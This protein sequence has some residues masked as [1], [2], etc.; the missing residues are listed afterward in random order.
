MKKRRIKSIANEEGLV[1]PKDQ[2]TIDL[3]KYVDTFVEEQREDKGILIT[4]AWI[5]KF[6]FESRDNNWKRL[7]VCN[8][9]TYLYWERL[10]G[11]VLSVNNHSVMLPHIK[12]VHQLQNFYYSLTNSELK[13]K[14]QI[15]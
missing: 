4:D 1:T 8:D 13:F 15:K 9:W 3:E 2:E 10:A 6:G 12:Y 14:P 7:C 5:M 11:L